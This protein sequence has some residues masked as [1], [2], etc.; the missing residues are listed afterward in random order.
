[1]AGSM[2]GAERPATD[3]GGVAVAVA[4]DASGSDRFR[5]RSDALDGSEHPPG[6][7]TKF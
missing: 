4:A 3:S 6:R 7:L 1:M 2:I 5:G